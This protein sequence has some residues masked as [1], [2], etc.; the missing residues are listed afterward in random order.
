MQS[1]YC[2]LFLYQKHRISFH[3]RV[4]PT[5][6]GGRIILRSSFWMFL[7]RTIQGLQIMFMGCP[8]PSSEKR[9]WRH[10]SIEKSQTICHTYCLMTQKMYIRETC[11][12]GCLQKELGIQGCSME[13]IHVQHT[14]MQID[15]LQPPN[16]IESH[17]ARH[18][19]RTNA[20]DAAVPVQPASTSCRLA[21]A[22][23]TLED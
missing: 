15:T 11:L 8:V 1:F 22:I 21:Y 2:F 14:S 20:R 12:T 16:T 6:A 23:F 9:N 7:K 5:E 13:T 10:H 17:A 18:C 19:A 4:Q 3:R